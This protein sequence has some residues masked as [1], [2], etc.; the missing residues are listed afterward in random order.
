[1]VPKLFSKTNIFANTTNNRY[2]VA[3][4]NSIFQDVYIEDMEKS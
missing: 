3:T 4:R 1:M 2:N